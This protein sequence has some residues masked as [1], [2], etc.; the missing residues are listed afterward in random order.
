MTKNQNHKN[1]FKT[2]LFSLLMLLV[3]GGVFYT[4]NYTGQ[5]GIDVGIIVTPKELKNTDSGKPQEVDFST[6]WEAWNKLNKNY[7][8]D[9]DP[10]NMVYGAI[11]G[12]LLSTGD[13]YTEYLKP[14]D[15]QRFKDDISGEFDGIG[16][17]ISSVNNMPTVVAPLSGS[18]AEAAGLK[19]KDIIVEVDGTKTSEI[20]FDE[21]I[22]R[23]RGAQGTKVVLKISRAGSD[24]LLE[25]SIERKN[26]KVD[27][28]SYEVKN[29]QDKKIFYIKVRQFGDDTEELF[30]KAANAAVASKASAVVLDLRNNPGGY[31]DTAVNMASY[32]LDGGLVV[33]EIDK[34]GTKK[35]FKTSRSAMLKDIKMAVLVNNGSASA[36]EIVAGALKDRNRATI[37]GEQTF[38]KGSVQILEN[39]SDGSAVKITIAKW[40]TPKGNHIDK[41]GITPDIEVSDEEDQ[42]LNRAYSELSK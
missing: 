38:G 33:S 6:F 7:V 41:V 32:F 40:L 22:N 35:E 28:V 17:E 18:P 3:L 30:E 4:G 29:Y 1:I 36:S 20:G 23:I 13:P 26:I 31:L 11:A 42:P 21:T 9:L 14:K 19:A 15:N 39:L 8:S 24:D 37:I 2:F 25:F 27:S 16:V 10:Q 34:N 5:R 12:L